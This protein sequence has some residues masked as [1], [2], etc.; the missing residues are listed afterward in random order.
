MHVTPQI[1]DNPVFH[2]YGCLLLLNGS[3]LQLNA[4][5]AQSRIAT[6]D[7]KHHKDNF[8]KMGN[9]QRYNHD[10][11]SKASTITTRKP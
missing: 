10:V 8:Y 3:S 2:S 7:V 4:G 6:L 11:Y 9:A 5:D 1:S